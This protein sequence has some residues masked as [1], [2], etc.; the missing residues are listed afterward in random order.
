MSPL[1][2]TVRSG[3][4][5]PAQRLLLAALLAM[6]PLAAVAQNHF[7][8]DLPRDGQPVALPPWLATS[9]APNPEFPNNIELYFLPTGK[10]LDLFITVV[11]EEIPGTPLRVTW[12]GAVSDRKSLIIRDLS[13]GITGLNQRVVRIPRRLTRTAGRLTFD[14]SDRPLP[15]RRIRADW[16]EATAIYA[17]AEGA[18]SVFQDAGGRLYSALELTGERL[19]SPPDAWVG[20]AL[21]ASLHERPES[22]DGNLELVIPLDA[23]PEAVRLRA[24]FAGIPLNDP[25]AIWINGAYMGRVPVNAPDLNDTGYL[26]GADGSPEYAGWRSA[27]IFIPTRL[28]K[29]GDN[30][31]LIQPPRTGTW[32]RNTT[33]QFR[34]SSDK[35]FSPPA[36]AK[37]TPSI[38]SPP[39]TEPE[40]PAPTPAVPEEVHWPSA[41]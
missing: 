24:E 4:A 34:F 27:S 16:V 17:A 5:N 19:L 41:K 40:R 1:A 31:V 13:E 28:L 14:S 32:I 23:V 10:S 18:A 37:E 6:A 30:T 26:R 22:L 21:E 3:R 9:P 11:F 35:P 36:P 20:K 39:P 8:W 29:A 2:T 7:T 15:I 25:P 33:L 12:T 38:A